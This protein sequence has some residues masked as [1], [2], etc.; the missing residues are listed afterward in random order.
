MITT[1]EIIATMPST[2]YQY[3]GQEITHR[4]TSKKYLKVI[5]VLATTALLLAIVTVALWQTGVIFSS[6]ADRGGESESA[7]NFSKDV[8]A[9]VIEI[10]TTGVSMEV[11]KGVIEI[12]TTGVPMGI[13]KCVTKDVGSDLASAVNDAGS[14]SK[15]Y[16]ATMGSGIKALSTKSA[17]VSSIIDQPESFYAIAYDRDRNRFY[18]TSSYKIYRSRADGTYVETLLET[19]RNMTCKRYWL[20]PI[21]HFQNDCIL[22]EILNSQTVSFGAWDGT[23][24]LVVSTL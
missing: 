8:T 23:G 16:F 1:V 13:T 3:A 14:D 22:C 21:L 2:R 10:V 17:Q 20:R 7:K 6:S 24:L 15:I 19:M 4:G 12:V 5:I 18:W 9:G 11:T